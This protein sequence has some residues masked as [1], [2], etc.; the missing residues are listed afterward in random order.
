MAP[1]DRFKPI[2]KVTSQKERKAAAALGESLKQREAAKQRLDELRQYLAEY[3]GRFESSARRGLSSNQVMEYQVFI[4]KLET[5]IAQQEQTVAES[6]QVCNSSKQH[7]R[8]RYSKS[9][10]MDNAIER[11]RVKERK[12]LERREQAEADER[13]QRKR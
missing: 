6:E 9:K 8:G 10:A 3:L 13:A 5:A 1:S 4:S 2:Q 7:W 12:I 11:M